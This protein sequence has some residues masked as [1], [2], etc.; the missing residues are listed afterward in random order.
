VLR[1]SV[2]LPVIPVRISPG[3]K[4]LPSGIFSTQ[5][6]TPITRRWRPSWVIACMAPITAAAPL[7]SCFISSMRSAGLMLMP[8]VS[9]VIPLP[10]RTRGAGFGAGGLVFEEDQLCLVGAAAA[11]GEQDMHA[12]LAHR[13]FAEDGALQPDGSGHGACAL[14]DFCRVEQIGGFV[15]EDTRQVDRGCESV[16]PRR[17]AG[18]DV[19][20]A[21]RVILDN[22]ACCG[23]GVGGGASVAGGTIGGHRRAFGHGLRR[24]DGVEAAASSSVHDGGEVLDAFE[25]GQ[26]LVGDSG[27]LAC[28]VC[29]KFFCFAQSDDQ[30][31]ARAQAAARGCRAS[32]AVARLA[33]EIAAGDQGLQGAVEGGVDRSGGAPG[34][35]TPSNRLTT[36]QSAVQWVIFP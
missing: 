4:A 6:A 7:M 18:G 28:A 1:I 19:G 11:H 12:Q 20:Q 24:S 17:T 25:P 21:Q 26:R 34:V 16:L 8:P 31:A 23:A 33:V 14:C 36:R 5:A 27:G 35:L 29:V 15:G 22:G 3:R 2:L 10:T 13:L 30:H 9:K 32:S